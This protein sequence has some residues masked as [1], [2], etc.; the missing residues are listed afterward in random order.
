MAMAVVRFG[1]TNERAAIH[2][3]MQ[4]AFEFSADHR[5][6]N[7]SNT[8]SHANARTHAVMDLMESAASKQCVHSLAPA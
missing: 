7:T 3:T 5:I 8:E 4:I 1:W 6:A 2:F